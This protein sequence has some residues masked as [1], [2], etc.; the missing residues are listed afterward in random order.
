MSRAKR[1]LSG[2]L[3]STCRAALRP[4]TM[5][6]S[7]FRVL[8]EIETKDGRI[9]M[10]GDLP[11]REKA[12]EFLDG[13]YIIESDG[14]D[15]PDGVKWMGFVFEIAASKVFLHLFLS[16][17]EGEGEFRQSMKSEIAS[18]IGAVDSERFKECYSDSESYG[19]SRDGL[20]AWNLEPAKW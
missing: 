7:V 17:S 13:L 6:S 5:T 4:Q 14:D 20:V 15:V 8:A 3:R 11:S 1:G 16:C 18:L 9:A 19:V 2:F 12:Q 10:R